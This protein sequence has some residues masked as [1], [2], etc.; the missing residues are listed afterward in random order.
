VP[1]IWDC[2]YPA[3]SKRPVCRLREQPG[4]RGHARTHSAEVVAWVLLGC[5][6]MPSLRQMWVALGYFTP[7]EREYVRTGGG[8]ASGTDVRRHALTNGNVVQVA[9]SGEYISGAAAGAVLFPRLCPWIESQS[10][11]LARANSESVISGAAVMFP[12]LCR[13]K[14]QAEGRRRPPPWVSRCAP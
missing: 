1:R 10:R 12:H 4:G 13:L 14:H 3:R 9:C 11:G 2:K 7:L 5:N 8:D 6:C